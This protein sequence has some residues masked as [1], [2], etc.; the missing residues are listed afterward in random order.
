MVLRRKVRLSS[1]IVWWVV[2][3]VGHAIGLMLSSLQILVVSSVMAYEQAYIR[4]QR[5]KG[6][7]YLIFTSS[8]L[9]PT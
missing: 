8:A 3:E 7:M 4:N 9:Q 1:L 5:H 2:H 6:Q